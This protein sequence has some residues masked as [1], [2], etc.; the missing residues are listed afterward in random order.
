MLILP[1]AAAASDKY[2]SIALEKANHISN[3]HAIFALS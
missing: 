2:P 1:V 3:F